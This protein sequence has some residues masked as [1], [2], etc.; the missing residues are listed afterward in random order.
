MA[1]SAEKD[2]ENSVTGSAP[3]APTG[4]TLS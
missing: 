4:L 1:V 3:A 2:L